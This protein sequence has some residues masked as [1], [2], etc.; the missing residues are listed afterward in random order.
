MD[1]KE[2]LG[3]AQMNTTQS[4]H[5]VTNTTYKWRVAETWTFLKI[6]I[7]CW[8]SML[9]LNTIDYILVLE[10]VQDVNVVDDNRTFM[11]SL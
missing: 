4:L 11:G 2:I 6:G 9:G 10:M 5:P 3:A 8:L 7:V 1:F